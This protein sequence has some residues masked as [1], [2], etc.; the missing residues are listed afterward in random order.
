[1]KMRRLLAAGA[2]I[3]FFLAGCTNQQADSG[4]EAEEINSASEVGTVGPFNR[5]TKI[6]EVR[7]DPAFGSYGRLIFPV[8]EG[9]W[10]G[11]TL[12]ELH[13]TWYN[14]IDPDKTVEIAN[15]LWQRAA[16]GETVFYDIYTDEEKEADPDKRLSL[17]HI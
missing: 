3:L 14:N 12:E 16:E 13:L 1:M 5:N 15:T 11:E 4:Q 2:C 9:Y 8:D 7:N 10:S 6:E 17:I